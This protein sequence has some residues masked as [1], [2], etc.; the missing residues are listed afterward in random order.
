[1]IGKS[2][3]GKGAAAPLHGKDSKVKDVLSFVFATIGFGMLMRLGS[4]VTKTL[5]NTITAK[6]T[7]K[8]GIGPSMPSPHS[9]RGF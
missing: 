8:P 6:L 5:G 7:N 9:P 3:L 1:M 4:E 2:K